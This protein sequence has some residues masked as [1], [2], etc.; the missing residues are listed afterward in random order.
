M[1]L[2]PPLP[3]YQPPPS[4]HAAMAAGLSPLL[5]LLSF[6]LLVLRLIEADTAL[7]TLLALAV[8]VGVELHRFQRATDRYNAAFA[9][10]HLDGRPTL[11]LRQWVADPAL[12]APTRGFVQRY[13]AAGC[14][15]LRDGQVA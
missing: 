10:D 1:S 13:L 5:V 6:T 4:R 7:A 9:R 3:P 12:S 2:P 15:V 8:W 14:T 11:L